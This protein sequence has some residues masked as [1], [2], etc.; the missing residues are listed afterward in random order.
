MSLAMEWHRL[1][2]P[3]IRWKNTT[4]GFSETATD[5]TCSWTPSKPELAKAEMRTEKFI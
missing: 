1:V 3:C 5:L 2:V 4:E